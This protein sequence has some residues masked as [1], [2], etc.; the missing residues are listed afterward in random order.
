MKFD[1][2]EAIQKQFHNVA[3]DMDEKTCYSCSKTIRLAKKYQTL[4]KN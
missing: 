1:K 3:K 2:T 4:P